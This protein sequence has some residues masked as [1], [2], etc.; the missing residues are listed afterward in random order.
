MK[1]TNESLTFMDNIKNGS[2]SQI[3]SLIASPKESVIKLKD[4]KSYLKDDTDF[5]STNIH[6]HKMSMSSVILQSKNKNKNNQPAA[7]FVT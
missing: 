2:T 1:N 6:S 5:I 7:D 3:N 4:M